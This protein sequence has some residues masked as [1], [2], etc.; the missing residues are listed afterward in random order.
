[1][2]VATTSGREELLERGLATMPSVGD[3]AAAVRELEE[4]LADPDVGLFIGAHGFGFLIAENN[5]S[6]FVNACTVIHF[7]SE[8]LGELEELLRECIAF[9]RAGGLE[10][11][12]GVDINGLTLRAYRRLLRGLPKNIRMLGAAYEVRV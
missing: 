9:A 10:R 3:P 12:Q 5:R 1:M 8:M 11:F 6:A 4:R 7:Y 2:R